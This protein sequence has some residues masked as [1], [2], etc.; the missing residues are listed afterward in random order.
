MPIISP[1]NTQLYDLPGLNVN[2]SGQDYTLIRQCDSGRNAV[3]LANVLNK[4]QGGFYKSHSV[5]LEHL[6]AHC[7]DL[8]Y[9]FKDTKFMI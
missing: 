6:Y 7:T 3:S 9:M 5:T 1:N 2:D 4:F 8:K